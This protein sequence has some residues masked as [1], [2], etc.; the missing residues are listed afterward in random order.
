MKTK[1]LTLFSLLCLSVPVYLFIIW[2][3]IFDK[4]DTQVER[5]EIYNSYLPNFMGNTTI[6]TLLSIL[7]SAAA[8]VLAVFSLKTSNRVLSAVN[9]LLLIV[10]G[11]VFILNVWSM[12]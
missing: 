1:V 6:S 4:A 10:A 9:I 5:V 7:F 2:I 11:L 3:S 12:L 8:A